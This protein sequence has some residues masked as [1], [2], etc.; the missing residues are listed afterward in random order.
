MNNIFPNKMKRRPKSQTPVP[1][2]SQTH[3][4]KTKCRTQ[5]NE[6]FSFK[7]KIPCYFQLHSKQE[8]GN[9]HA[10]W[11]RNLVEKDTRYSLYTLILLDNCLSP[12]NSNLVKQQDYTHLQESKYTKQVEKTS[13]EPPSKKHSSQPNIQE[14]ILGF[15]YP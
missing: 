6:S 7:A 14:K 12:S 2:E 8:K 3:L 5:Q 9:T 15:L 13:F 1:F 4:W 11:T 10:K